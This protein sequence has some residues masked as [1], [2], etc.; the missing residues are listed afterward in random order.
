M[1]RLSTIH[2]RLNSRRGR[3]LTAAS[4][5]L[6]FAT[7][8]S[9][10]SHAGKTP[11]SRSHPVAS[12]AQTP[13]ASPR[14]HVLPTGDGPGARSLRL[15]GVQV[16]SRIE[17]GRL[18]VR[19]MTGS[20]GGGRIKASG[21]IDPADKAGP[22]SIQAQFDDVNLLDVL[23]AL[24]IETGAAGISG[25]RADGIMNLQWRGLDPQAVRHSITGSATI[26]SGAGVIASD[27]PLLR[28]LGQAAGI[29]DLGSLSFQAGR[30][31]ATAHHGVLHIRSLV[32]QG[33]QF[34]LAATGTIGLRNER[35]NLAMD[36][37]VTEDLAKRSR[38]YRLQE[39]ASL[40]GQ[41]KPQASGDGL[42]EVPRIVLGG[43]MRAPEVRIDTGARASTSATAQGLPAPGREIASKE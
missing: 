29:S 41:K 12:A 24:G 19:G 7:G 36:I 40:F 43:S 2:R 3:Q 6:A 42:V 27:S 28:R 26:K 32:F 15:Q 13:A 8:F 11:S 1:I 33:D 10:R 35:I 31:E 39:L 16:R 37:D 23:S 14:Q 20:V 17:N 25:V 4:C 21:R 9:A 22:Q 18:I 30:V 38:Y 34:R 5:A